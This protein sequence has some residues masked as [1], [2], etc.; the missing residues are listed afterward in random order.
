M[1]I[2]TFKFI[3]VLSLLSSV[4]DVVVGVAVVKA[5]DV[6]ARGAWRMCMEGVVECI[7]PPGGRGSSCPLLQPAVGRSVAA[8][9][10]MLG[11]SRTRRPTVGDPSM[12]REGSDPDL[13]A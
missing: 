1:V 7:F 12:V 6:S 5:T 4:P 11:S 10:N 13:S 2:R 8:R 9:W 3:D